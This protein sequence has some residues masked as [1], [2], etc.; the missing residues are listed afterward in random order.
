MVGTVPLRS[1]GRW[2]REGLANS[3]TLAAAEATL[4]RS[5][6]LLRARSGELFPVSMRMFPRPAR[7]RPGLPSA[8]RPRNQPF[9]LYNASVDV[10][11]N[12]DLFGRTRRELE[13][14]QAQVDY[15]RFQLEGPT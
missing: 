1:A 5:Q 8:S 6:E 3:P 11:Y 7:N 14:L 13:A 10:S 2:I 4:R 9:T 15:E 12:L